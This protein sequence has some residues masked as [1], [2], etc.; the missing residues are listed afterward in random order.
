MVYAMPPVDQNAAL[1]GMRKRNGVTIWHTLRRDRI[2][3]GKDSAVRRHDARQLDRTRSLE[4]LLGRFGGGE[5]VYDPTGAFER[6]RRLVTAARA[7]RLAGG[8]R[9]VSLHLLSCGRVLY[10]RAR[11]PEDI[12]HIAPVV[13]AALARAI[14]GCDFQVAVKFGHQRPSAGAMP[15]ERIGAR[16][17]QVM[18]AAQRASMALAVA[19][20][21]FY[22]MQP[23]SAD[24][25]EP[26]Q[27]MLTTAGSVSASMLQPAL[28][29]RTVHAIYSPEGALLALHLADEDRGGSEESAQAAMQLVRDQTP[30][31]LNGAI[32]RRILA[33]PRAWL[34]ARR[35]RS[36][37]GVSYSVEVSAAKDSEDPNP[38][39]VAAAALDAAAAAPK[40]EPP[41]PLAPAPLTDITY[42]EVGGA[43]ISRGDQAGALALAG[44]QF[45]ATPDV[46]IEVQGALG[47]I[48]GEVAG[49]AEIGAQHFITYDDDKSVAFGAYVS[50]VQSTAPSG[51]D[52]SIF[53]GA[54]GAEITTNKY[55][56]IVRGGYASG[57]GDL[58]ESGGFARAE[59]AWFIVPELALEAFA[60]Q[61]PTTGAGA[62]VGITA[63]P[64]SGVL[65]NMM[66]D[67]DASWHEDGE[68]SFR[69]GLRWLMGRDRQGSLRDAKARRGIAGDLMDD[70]QRLPDELERSSGT[71]TKSQP[72]CGGVTP[73]PPPS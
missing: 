53:R 17:D 25:R 20:A 44:V 5:I 73:C 60:E 37:D 49:G 46:S 8:R 34:K 14:S 11:A 30:G 36:E 10:A 71:T 59:G 35:H 47:V 1:L 67:A 24:A 70:L 6:A 15:L 42:G 39:P 4:G 65:A 40:A 55:Q 31:F 2:E 61:D 28:P 29:T 41:R 68:D 43:V 19:G 58:D 51:E 64:F 13:G 12:E 72:Y 45:A 63:K 9:L 50:G 23:K 3:A 7:A 56:L 38:T 32:G 69:L 54:L 62:G 22:G 48:D 66:I 33:G 57:G 27:G 26:S 52:F 21:V 18:A 16:R